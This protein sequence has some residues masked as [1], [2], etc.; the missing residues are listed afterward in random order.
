MNI[1]DVLILLFLLSGIGAGFARGFLKQTVI[2]I[3]TI[4]VVILSFIFKNPLSLMMY[5]ELPF[6]KFGGIF[7]GLTS[8]NILMYEILAFIIVAVILS[9]VLAVIVK[10]TGLIE[11]LLKMTI[12]LAIPSKILGMVV[13]FIQSF[14]IVYIVLFVL[15]LPV[16]NLPYLKDSKYAKLIL[17]NTPFLSSITSGINDTYNEINIFLNDTI[18][19]NMDVETKNTNMVEIMLQNNVTTTESIKLLVDKKKI[20]IH[21]V[22]E[23]IEKYK[24]N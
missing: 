19:K 16:I 24:E 1:V 18:N 9:I 20:E 17:N 2:S 13:G 7:Y 21:N 14:V 8:L 10:I 4:L 6:F 12:I 22:N 11:K 23:L 5:K 15:S 3:G